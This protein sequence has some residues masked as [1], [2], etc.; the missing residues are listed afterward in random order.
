MYYRLVLDRGRIRHFQGHNFDGKPLPDVETQLI[1]AGAS[2]IYSTPDDVLRWLSWH[3]DRFASKDAEVRLLDH[4]AYLQR[5]GLNPVSAASCARDTGEY[6]ALQAFSVYGD[7]L[8]LPFPDGLR[9][10]S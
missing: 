8:W 6:N 2:E 7:L 4:A 3:L 1:A 10:S 9:T 5:D